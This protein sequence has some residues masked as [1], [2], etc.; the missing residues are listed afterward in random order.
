MIKTDI[1]MITTA[2]GGVFF[3]DFSVF[4]QNRVVFVN[5]KHCQQT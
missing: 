5:L 3:I 2:V 1:A 4:N